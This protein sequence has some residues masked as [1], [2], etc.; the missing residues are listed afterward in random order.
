MICIVRGVVTKGTANIY[1]NGLMGKFNGRCLQMQLI[2]QFVKLIFPSFLV[3][4]QHKGPVWFSKL[5]EPN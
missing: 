2:M 3:M 5:L 4:R 1:S